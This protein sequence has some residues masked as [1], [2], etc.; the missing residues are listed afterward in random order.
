M[1]DIPRP[2]LESVSPY[3]GRQILNHCGTGEAPIYPFIITLFLHNTLAPWYPGHLLCLPAAVAVVC[4]VQGALGSEE[5]VS[6]RTPRRREGD[7]EEDLRRRGS[8]GL[9][10]EM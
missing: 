2:G 1:W 6:P 7:R 4:G 5:A 9:G 10:E 8:L 3:I